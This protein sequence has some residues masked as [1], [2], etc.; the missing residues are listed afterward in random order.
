M[1]VLFRR[2]TLFTLGV[3][4]LIG[5]GC[6]SSAPSRFYQL[7]SLN[8]ENMVALDD[9]RQRSVIIAV[10]PV[11]IPDYLD[12]P[13]IVTRYNNNE[14]RLGEFDRWAGSL[15]QDISRVLVENI[16]ILLPKDLFYV[17]RWI[18]SA[19]SDTSASYRVEVNIIRFDG[20]T[21]ESALLEAQ[22]A[23]FDKERKMILKRE[24]SINER[25]SGNSYK[26]L[27]SALSNAL[28][29]ISRDIANA[30]MSL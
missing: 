16:S 24:S 11:R 28:G 14:L 5:T 20:V 3:A 6:A 21:G 12:R 18:S 15:E 22:W 13:Q 27:V 23:V 19:Q 2:V 17:T 29:S 8:T 7:N 10:G 30:I 4:L 26:A 9:S 1:N 25:V